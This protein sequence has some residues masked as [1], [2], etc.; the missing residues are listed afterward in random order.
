M[1]VLDHGI[2]IE[3]L[4][5][6]GIVELLAHRIG[7]GGM[8]VQD[9]QVQLIRPPL[10]IRVGPSQGVSASFVRY[11]AFGFGCHAL[12]LILWDS[13]PCCGGEMSVHLFYLPSNESKDC[14]ELRTYP[15][16]S[17]GAMAV[18]RAC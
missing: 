5:F 11:R 9:P 17:I 12:L 15:S 1:E 3:A 14:Y 18:G 10:R 2:Q 13:C 7:K 4:K 6:F 8:L 16:R